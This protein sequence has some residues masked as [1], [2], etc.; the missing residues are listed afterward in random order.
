MSTVMMIIIITEGSPIYL[1]QLNSKM[2]QKSPFR[3]FNH[4]PTSS[5]NLCSHSDLL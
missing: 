2:V 4:L 1:Y 3:I 5:S